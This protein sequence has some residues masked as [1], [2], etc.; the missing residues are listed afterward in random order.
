[1]NFNMVIKKPQIER[2][3][4]CNLAFEILNCTIR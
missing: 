3:D 4:F 2:D 1:M